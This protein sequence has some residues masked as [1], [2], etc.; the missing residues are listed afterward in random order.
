MVK[1]PLIVLRGLASVVIVFAPVFGDWFY[2]GR[3]I[4]IG[5]TRLLPKFPS[6]VAERGK[7]FSSVVSREL[8]NTFILVRDCGLCLFV[9]KSFRQ[10]NP[11]LVQDN[12]IKASGS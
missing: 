9:E 12:C 3:I 11:S 2:G 8:Y 7:E 5:R 6:A 10:I 1:D 4:C